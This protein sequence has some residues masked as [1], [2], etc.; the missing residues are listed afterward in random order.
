MPASSGGLELVDLK[1]TE[2]IFLLNELDHLAQNID[3]LLIDTGAGISSNVLYFNIAA[4][5]SIIIAT[6]EPTSITAAYA[7]I[8]VL[9]VKFQKKNFMILVNLASGAQEGKEVF[10]KINLAVDRLLGS[11]SLDYLGFIPVDE[12]I[13]KAVK[14]QKAVLEVYPNSLFSKGIRELA[15]TISER[16]IQRTGDGN[17][18]FF[19]KQLLQYSG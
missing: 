10:K 13:S 15:Q 4:P 2:K 17:I 5:E 11:L 18:Q 7:L 16:P 12:S 6:P 3:V 1:E 14:Q 9:A 8:K 19:W